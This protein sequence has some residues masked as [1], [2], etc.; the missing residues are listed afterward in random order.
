MKN[1]NRPWSPRLKTLQTGATRTLTWIAHSHGLHR[2]CMANDIDTT[3][4]AKN[5]IKLNGTK[6]GLLHFQSS[7]QTEAYT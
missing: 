3:K 2:A 1:C 6:T 7:Q 5:F 4:A